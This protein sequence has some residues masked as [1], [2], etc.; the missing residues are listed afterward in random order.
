MS[1]NRAQYFN[2]K[3]SKTEFTEQWFSLADTE[4]LYT[5]SWIKSIS[6]YKIAIE[7][8]F[9]LL[10]KSNSR[11]FLER[12]LFWREFAFGM[13]VNFIKEHFNVISFNAHTRSKAVGWSKTIYWPW[14]KQGKVAL[15]AWGAANHTFIVSEL[16]FPLS[17]VS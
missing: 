6:D 8:S 16:L 1:V 2:P 13:N 12:K 5:Y 7:L 17:R 15:A 9:D 4:I 11:M 10:Q 14:M 3:I